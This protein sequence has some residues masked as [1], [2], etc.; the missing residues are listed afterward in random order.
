MIKLFK[1]FAECGSKLIGTGGGLK[2]ALDTGE[3]LYDL[4]CLHTADEAADTLGVPAAAAYEYGINNSTVIRQGYLYLSRA[5][6]FCFI[7][8][9]FVHFILSF[10]AIYLYMGKTPVRVH[11]TPLRARYIEKGA[12]LFFVHL[13]RISRL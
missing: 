3:S 4:L 9:M 13:R 5:S 11:C 10:Q 2:A 6:T 7:Y 1:G 12:K 8:Y